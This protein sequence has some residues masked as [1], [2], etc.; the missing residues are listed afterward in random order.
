MELQSATMGLGRHGE[1][2]FKNPKLNL[3]FN[4]G[5]YRNP[6]TACVEKVQTFTQKWPECTYS[7]CMLQKPHTRSKML[8]SHWEVER[9]PNL[10][11]SG[12]DDCRTQS[13]A[14]PTH[15]LLA[16]HED[17]K[18]TPICPPKRAASVGDWTIQDDF[19]RQTA[20]KLRT[21]HQLLWR[22]TQV[23]VDE[24]FTTKYKHSTQVSACWRSNVFLFWRDTGT[25][26][27]SPWHSTH[28]VRTTFIMLHPET[29]GRDN[30]MTK[31]RNNM[32]K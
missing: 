9:K 10:W 31:A 3:I 29:N 1:T 20:W 12:G 21:I 25:S 32:V 24:N 15:I 19:A 23:Q 8:E 5:L 2:H 4:C 14:V 16:V 22:S 11:L 30:P 26:W 17:R 27:H 28:L 6:Y 18:V 13:L 7:T